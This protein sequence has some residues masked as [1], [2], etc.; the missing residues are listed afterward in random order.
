MQIPPFRWIAS[1]CLA[2]GMISPASAN[3]WPNWRGP[4]QSGVSL[5]HYRGGA[6]R[7]DAEPVWTYDS[8][9]RGCPVV[10]DGRVYSFGYR[11]EKEE[12]VELLTCLDEATGKK[13]WEV[14]IKDFI[15]DTVYNRY[16]IGSPVVDPESRRV[17]LLT[18]YGVFG[19]WDLD[20]KEIWRHSL[21]EEL[22][23]LTFPNSKVGAPVVEGDLV[24]VRGITANW[25]ATGPAADRFYGFDKI[26]GELVWSSTP[27]TIP[28]TDSSFSTPVLETRDGKRVFYC[29]TGCGNVVCVNARDGVPLWRFKAGKVGINASVVLHGNELISIHGDENVDS[30][31]RGRMA[32]LKLPEKFAAEEIQLDPEVNEAAW[33][34]VEAWR[35]DL[36]AGSSSPVLHG[37]KVYQITDQGAVVC[38]NAGT[39]AV[40][41]E[42]KVSNGNTHSSPV[43]A[44]GFVYAPLMEGKVFVINA[45][46]GAVVQELQLE[47]NC[48]G[49]A[50]V[51]NG[52]LMVHS[53]KHL[54]RFKILHEEVMA[55]AAPQPVIP[56]PGASA[57]LQIIPSEFT[58]SPGNSV[59][60]RIRT[61]DANGF[62]T[63][64]VKAADAKW[65]SF[66]PPTAKVKS[67]ADASFNAD[68]Q[69]VAAADAK[70]S[71]GAFKA[72]AGGLSGVIRGRVL[73]APP[74]TENFN[75]YELNQLQEQEGVQFAYPPLAW[76]G[77]RFKF[78]I[79]DL[80]GEK[81]FAKTFD[82]LL[83][84]RATV[85][86]GTESMSDYTV[87]ADVMTD[88]N[89]RV[90]SDVGIINQR[91]A[92][93]LKG[94]ANVL[95]IS[96]NFERLTRTAPFKVEA[97]K[98]Y[99]LKSQVQVNDDG[100]GVVMAK[101]WERGAEEPADW[102]IS[103]EVPIVHKS[104]SPGLFGFTPQN[105][106]KVFIDNVIVTPNH[107]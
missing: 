26:T 107:P 103:A 15:S 89:R 30:T 97:N 9:S 34:S 18:A 2:F 67:T 95:E 43:Y 46:D 19:C 25:G 55:D 68:G 59:S 64:E 75:E 61:V 73:L 12:L 79:R 47:G 60:F 5:E 41:W 72:T 63:G 32:A 36:G 49:A 56:E 104:G 80:D 28:P 101:V 20:G 29:A 6:G 78:D 85:F 84:Q 24:I 93:V 71:A 38:V 14:E 21:M 91:Y 7:V 99:T 11:G 40:E 48:I 92:I 58:V 31:T 44:D 66:I 70:M 52:Y 16:A 76:I 69:L 65:E 54:Y 1:V 13:L 88:G 37:D 50:M 98:W 94:N 74:F 102:T 23:R 90:K 22:G 62:V 77:A 106:K 83:F 86:I 82:R 45:Q 53:T 4:L 35:N 8:S 51:C 96:S 27:G 17:Y 81:V 42:A 100:T 105:Q 10:F 3:D 87:Q 39:G 33:K 57:A